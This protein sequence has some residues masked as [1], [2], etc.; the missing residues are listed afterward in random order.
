MSARAIRSWRAQAHAV[1][2][3]ERQRSRA[4]Q[5]GKAMWECFKTCSVCLGAYMVVSFLDTLPAE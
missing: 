3:A 4:K 5:G 2:G 1:C